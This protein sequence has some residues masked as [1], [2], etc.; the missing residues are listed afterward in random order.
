LI[1]KNSG[2]TDDPFILKSAKALNVRLMNEAGLM[3]ENQ[4]RLEL[5]KDYDDPQ[6][7]FDS[8]GNIKSRGKLQ[9]FWTGSIW[10][11][12]AGLLSLAP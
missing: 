1:V 2:Q 8:R 7:P 11:C 9:A 10:L 3:R 5:R 6:L 4:A 12:L